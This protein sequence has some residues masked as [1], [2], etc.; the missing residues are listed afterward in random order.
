VFAFTGRLARACARRPWFVVLAWLL[1][2]VL[3]G[4]FARGLGNVVN[5]NLGL[6]FN[7]ESVRASDLL[8]A[9]LRGPKPASEIVMVQS[10]DSTVDDPSFESFVSGL[11]AA[12]Q[13]LKNK[14]GSPVVASVAS[15]YDARNAAFVSADRHT[16]VLPVNMNAPAEESATSVVPLIKLLKEYNGRDGFTVL[17]SGEG[18]LNNE[19]N[20]VAQKDLRRAE[21]IGVPVAL[22][23]LVLVFGAVV[24]AGVPLILAAFAIVVALGATALVG[25][26]LPMD[27]VVE[28][29]IT[30]V[31]LAVGIDYSLLVV[32]RFREERRGGR[33]K[34]D[35][36]AVAGATASKAVLFSG[37][38]V[39]VSLLALLIVPEKTFRSIGLGASVVVVC[40]VA[41]A[42]TLLPAVLS[43]IGD[44][45]SALALRLPGRRWPSAEESVFWARAAGLVMARPWISVTVVVVFLAAAAAPFFTMQRGFAGVG[46]VPHDTDVYRAYQILDREFSAGLVFPLEVAVDAPDVKSLA[47]QQGIN[48]LV[49]RLQKDGAF[50]PPTVEVNP[51]GDLAL[52][53]APVNGDF[54]AK[55]AIDAVNRV[56]SQYVPG[57]FAGTDA[58]VL[59]GGESAFILDVLNMVSDYTP[60]VFVFVLGLSFLLL[61][62]LFRSIVVPVSAIIMNL[63]SVGAAYGLLV[64][65]FQH[66]FLVG[67][68]GFRRV[69]TIEF[70]IP[71]LLFAFLFGL[72]MDYHVF[73]LSRIRERYDERGDNREAVSFGVRHTGRIITGAA[74]IMVV[75]FAAFSMG[76]MS[77]LQQMGFGLAVA[78]IIDATVIRTVLVPAVM[79]LLGRWNWYLPKWLNWLPDLRMEAGV[80]QSRGVSAAGSKEDGGPG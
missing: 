10:A 8:D 67:V 29:M 64:L 26:L 73:L 20:A 3:G 76:R 13:G 1:L 52:V 58:R 14:D 35:A 6:Y 45:V 37:G 7:P 46:M 43:L 47:V 21:L 71:L 72:S 59:V 57:A 55:G 54:A 56:R 65:V 19:W 77:Q 18:S 16:T 24:A 2:L 38:T 22:A 11:G 70:W 5:S 78:V 63:L 33:E 25:R 75:V 41:A 61:L 12:I 80:W 50:G 36:I 4:L 51:A 9:R 68:L 17:T 40:A 49:S 42:L 15:F 53:S 28:N 34:V 31:G 69:E 79:T 44:R 39:I 30:M 27:T 48:S 66:G 32:E 60:I 23:V 62:L 74:L